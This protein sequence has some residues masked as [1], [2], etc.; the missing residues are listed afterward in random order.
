MVNDA[1]YEADLERASLTPFPDVVR[2]DLS[3]LLRDRYESEKLSRWDVGLLSDADFEVRVAGLASAAD[4]DT[5]VQERKVVRW[6]R[7]MAENAPEAVEYLERYCTVYAD[8]Q[9]K[10]AQYF[11]VGVMVKFYP[12]QAD[13]NEREM[14]AACAAINLEMKERANW[15][16][17]YVVDRV[18]DLS[19]WFG[20]VPAAVVQGHWTR[21]TYFMLLRDGHG[22]PTTWPFNNP[23]KCASKASEEGEVAAEEMEY[24]QQAESEEAYPDRKLAEGHKA[25]LLREA[26]WDGEVGADGKSYPNAAF[27]KLYYSYM[28]DN[29]LCY[30]CG[31]KY[32][33][34][35]PQQHKFGKDCPKGKK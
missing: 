30:Q 34:G 3:Y 22:T 29:Q 7:D 11:S 5:E 23:Q 15:N 6:V 21:S 28:K 27:R 1:K 35:H 16:H 24:S 4:R 33:F 12:L 13:L 20:S 19:R 8:L 17:N 14:A 26:N 32:D 31:N 9:S 2:G 25:K 10:A 18:P